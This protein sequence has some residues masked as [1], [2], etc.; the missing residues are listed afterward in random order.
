MVLYN[1]EELSRLLTQRLREMPWYPQAISLVRAHAQGRIYL[2]GGAVSRT[3]AA[4]LYGGDP[5]SSDFD[6]VVE[7]LDP[8]IDVPSGWQV[9]YHKFGSPT[10]SRESCEV[11]VFALSDH[12]YIRTHNLAPT[13][14][15]FLSSV[16]FTIQALAYD[17]NTQRLIGDAGIR[18]LQD[19]VFRVNNRETAEEVACRK[20]ITVEERMRRKAES[21]GFGVETDDA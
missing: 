19:R 13:I 15:N 1:E 11:D 8:D 3:L 5:E 21:M 16:P 18:A 7:Q 2:I 17:I 4:A 10:F 9:S 6:F 14:Q 12:D 20:G